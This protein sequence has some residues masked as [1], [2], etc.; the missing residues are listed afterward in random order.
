MKSEFNQ[1]VEGLKIGDRFIIEAVEGV[2]CTCE[3]CVFDS[4]DI[5][6][7]NDCHRLD[8]VIFKLVEEK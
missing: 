7:S 3:G 2:D 5:L 6:C 8:N 4:D 1:K